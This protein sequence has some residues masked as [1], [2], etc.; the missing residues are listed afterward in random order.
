[1]NKQLVIAQ[2]RKEMYNYYNK[3][4]DPKGPIEKYCL[5]WAFFTVK[6]IK[7]NGGNAQIQAGTAYWPIL[8]HDDGV[9]A[10]QYG[11]KFEWNDYALA[12]VACNQ[13]PEMHVWAAILG[14]KAEIVDITAPFFKKRAIE[15]GFRWDAPDPPDFFWD[16]RVPAGV[17]YL[18]DVQA[19]EIA[20]AMIESN[21]TEKPMAIQLF[22]A[23][24][25]GGWENARD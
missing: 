19:I 9:S 11:F 6:A 15:E 10:N 16:H 4:T 17:T 18:P 21:F 8:A 13:F 3:M 23:T 2:A 24:K 14:K 5:F 12:Q 25:K 1:M 22:R 7:N 20:L